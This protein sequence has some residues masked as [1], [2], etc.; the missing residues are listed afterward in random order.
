MMD[1]AWF[2][3][4]EDT[5]IG[6]RDI[7]RRDY[8]LTYK[9]IMMT[10]EPIRLVLPTDFAMNTVNAY[11]FLEPEPV[12][13][14]CGEKSNKVW[15]ALQL[16]L[17]G[18]GLKISDLKKVIITHAHVDH[19]G[20]SGRIARE[21]DA[22]IWVSELVYPW[23]LDMKTQ[24]NSRSEFINEV[25]HKGGSP[26][27]ITKRILQ[28]MDVMP[29]FWESVPAE[30]LYIFKLDEILEI[31]GQK[32][33]V[34]HVPGHAITQTGFYQPDNQWFISADMLM[35]I[36]PVPVIEREIEGLGRVKGL[37]VML[38]SYQKVDNM[39]IRKVFPG[40]GEVFGEHQAIIKQQVA[41]IH[42][43]KEE[44]L[45]F[46]KDGYKEVFALS[47]QLY[48]DATP[49]FQFAGFAMTL[50]YL[51]LLESENKIYQEEK[52]GIWQFHLSDELF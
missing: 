46:V 26:T 41:R 17:A 3:V 51:D 37:P 2:R 23:A 8:E 25:W 6:H 33:Q 48:R 39:S 47:E 1:F 7:S 31:G 35:Y 36:T 38:E 9:K 13:I 28:G 4:C 44:C 20:M 50:G 21:T 16:E 14:D 40:H 22:E 52:N 11:L 10:Q 42:Q 29:H 12:L 32:W 45:E 18:H 5:G 15:D 43:R 27:D 24:W 49:V 34:T 30:K 19:I